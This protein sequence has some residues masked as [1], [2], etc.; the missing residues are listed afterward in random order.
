MR[1]TEQF[2]ITLPKEMAAEVRH[3]V[4]SGLYATESEVLRD[5]LRT[6]LARDKALESWLNG[7]VAAAYDAYKAHPENVLDGEEVKARLGEL[8]ASR[9]RGK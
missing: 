4:E 3:R 7:R 8:R 9:K 6:L 5:G 1:K 2:S